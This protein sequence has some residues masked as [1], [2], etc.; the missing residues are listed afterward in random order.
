MVPYIAMGTSSSYSNTSKLKNL[1]G[2]SKVSSSKLFALA[3]SASPNTPGTSPSKVMSMP[4]DAGPLGFLS[5]CP[6]KD[7]SQALLV[8]APGYATASMVLASSPANASGGRLLPL[9]LYRSKLRKLWEFNRC[10]NTPSASM[11]T[12]SGLCCKVALTL[13]PVTVVKLM[14]EASG[15]VT[16]FISSA[17]VGGGSITTS[18]GGISY[19]GCSGSSSVSLIRSIPVA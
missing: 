13:V 17:L 12:L 3:C 1:I 10:T 15:L 11:A 14:M 4:S 18:P 8:S 16:I 6:P 19:L 2:S 7:S 9:L 5:V